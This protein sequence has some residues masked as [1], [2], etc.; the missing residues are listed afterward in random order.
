MKPAPFD[1]ARPEDLPG[2]VKALALDGARALAGGQSLGPMLNLRLARPGLLVDL[3]RIDEL[4]QVADRGDRLVLGAMT[5]HAAIEDG[6]VPDTT[7]GMLRSVARDIAYRAVRTR[8]TMGGSLAHADPAADWVNALTALG[9]TIRVR[10]A[11]GERAVPMPQFMTGAFATDLGD[12]GGILAAIEIPTLSA[13]ARWGYYKI[14]RKPG[15]FAE[16]IGAVVL[17]PAREFRRIVMG[18]VGGAPLLLDAIAR[19]LPYEGTPSLSRAE[20][21]A[22]T[23]ADM[24]AIDR[25]LHVVAVE[26]AL[27]QAYA[28]GMGAQ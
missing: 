14:C 7:R 8:G 18:A 21:E 24:D 6:Q 26:R 28:M 17:D 10:G 20:I 3:R 1:Y 5:T 11:G 22:A 15:E 12:G 27:A 23:P 13:K 19:R 4:R 9:A 25:Q 16:A 2:A